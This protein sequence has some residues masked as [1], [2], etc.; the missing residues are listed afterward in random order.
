M[1]PL[2]ALAGERPYRERATRVMTENGQFDRWLA[3]IERDMKAAR[4]ARGAHTVGSPEDYLLTAL[5]DK[6][7]KS[8]LTL[9]NS[10][11]Y[12]SV[13]SWFDAQAMSISLRMHR[14]DT[15]TR[16]GVALN[17]VLN[18]DAV[19]T[20]FLRLDLVDA[21][22]R[23]Q[24]A[25]AVRTLQSNL[26]DRVLPSL[27]CLIDSPQRAAD[28]DCNRYFQSFIHQGNRDSD[29]QNPTNQTQRG[30]DPVHPPLPPPPPALTEPRIVFHAMDSWDDSP[31]SP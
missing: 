13:A 7:M 24:Y 15:V 11:N 3:S 27:V 14:I 5:S 28:Y 2:F 10:R 6:I 20:A 26:E 4:G 22:E 29:F 19:S 16:A 25:V 23:D 9:T 18:C 8:L 31:K 12:S 21:F 30:D 17:R 1:S